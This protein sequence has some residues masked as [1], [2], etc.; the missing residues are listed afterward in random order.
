MLTWQALYSGSLLPKLFVPCPYNPYSSDL[1]VLLHFQ[2]ATSVWEWERGISGSSM[3]SGFPAVRNKTHKDHFQK[4]QSQLMFRLWY[5]CP[6]KAVSPDPLKTDF[7]LKANKTCWGRTCQ[8][9]GQQVCGRG[10]HQC[11][12]PTLPDPLGHLAPHT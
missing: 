10:P 8:W 7:N 9:D 2:Q 4:W 12:V 3:L 6:H 5:C 11:F 1:A